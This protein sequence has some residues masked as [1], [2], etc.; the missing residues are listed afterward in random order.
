MKNWLELLWLPLLIALIGSVVG[1]VI[2]LWLEHRTSW[3]A[4]WRDRRR[5]PQEPAPA[6]GEDFSGVVQVGDPLIRLSRRAR[7]RGIL[8]IGKGRIQVSEGQPA[9]REEP[10]A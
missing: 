6:P 4:R 2:L 8:Q 7:L 5:R 3:F 1:G 10:P 9:D